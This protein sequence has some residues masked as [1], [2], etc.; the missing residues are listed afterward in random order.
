MSMSTM[1]NNGPGQAMPARVHMRLVCMVQVKLDDLEKFMVQVTLDDLEAL[2]NR[3]GV[4]P[5]A[6]L[7]WSHFLL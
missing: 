4:P 5:H 1:P 3:S 6:A 2:C 7:A